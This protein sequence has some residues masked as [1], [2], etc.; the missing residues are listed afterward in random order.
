MRGVEFSGE[1]TNGH[2]PQ[3]QRQRI[4]TLLRRME[5]K[6]VVVEIKPYRKRRSLPQNNYYK[7]VVVPMFRDFLNSYG[8]NVSN[9]FADR[10]L[11]L[12]VDFTREVKMPD[13]EIEIEPRSTTELS[14]TEF[15]EF[16]E[17]VIAWAALEWNFEIPLPNETPA[18]ETA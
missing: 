5:G 14:T 7:G 3:E 18:G 13:G 9:E 15:N 2:L 8:N 17:K 12:G 6:R 11:K 16:V 1:V 10:M 4:T